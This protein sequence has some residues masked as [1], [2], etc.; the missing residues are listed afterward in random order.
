M[1]CAQG[2]EP[3][4]NWKGYTHQEKN[5]SETSTACR[6]VVS[7]RSRLFTPLY[8]LFAPAQRHNATNRLNLSAE[9]SWA[10]NLE[11]KEKV[12]EERHE[13]EKIKRDK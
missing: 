5:E 12:M 7:N 13:S 10:S 9:S 8:L 1:G 4:N 2:N 11:L 6:V 3:A